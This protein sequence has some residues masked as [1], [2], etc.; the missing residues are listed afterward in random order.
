MAGTVRQQPCIPFTYGQRLD[1]NDTCTDVSK[2]G[3][4]TLFI[5]ECK[6]YGRK[7]NAFAYC[8]SYSGVTLGVSTTISIKPVWEFVLHDGNNLQWYEDPNLSNL[9]HL[10]KTSYFF[11]WTLH[12]ILAIRIYL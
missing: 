10:K 9:L 11:V 3:P 1:E 6:S 7:L 2:N 12:Q 4:K 8:S 5:K